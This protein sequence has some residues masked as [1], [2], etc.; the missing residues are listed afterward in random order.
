MKKFYTF[1]GTG[2]AVYL[3]FGQR[4]ED[5]R[6]IAC[7]DGDT[8]DLHWNRAMARALEMCEGLVYAGAGAASVLSKGAGVV[9]YDGGDLLTADN[10][11]ST[12]YGAGIYLGIDDKDYSKD[13]TYG[14][15]AVID[16][17]TLG[18]ASNFT[19]KFNA[20]TL[21]SGVTRIGE[22][23]EIDI[24]DSVGKI[25]TAVITALTAGQG[26]TANEVT[27]S[28]AVPSG[29]VVRISGMYSLAPL[30]LGSITPAGVKLNIAAVINH[31]DE[32]QAV[33]VDSGMNR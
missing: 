12:T 1:N 16:A 9:P 22:G 2:A 31:T 14:G 21:A 33:V 8:A 25:H 18:S 27:L 20:D 10:Q 24:M 32:I 13:L 19:G 23:S 6:I 26:I 5:I 28:E 11:T 7:E 4:A 29:K 3:C 15:T 30:P 17:W